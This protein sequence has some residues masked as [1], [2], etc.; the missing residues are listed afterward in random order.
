MP[1]TGQCTSKT[2]TSK[3]PENSDFNDND[4]IWASDDEKVSAYADRQ[5]AQVNQGYL[6]GLTAAQELGL[7]NGFDSGYPEGATLGIRVGKV[8]AKLHGTALFDQAKRELNITK[9]L[10]SK[11]YDSHLDVKAPDHQLVE[12]WEQKAELTHSR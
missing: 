10:D 3:K 7:Q 9:V 2:K 6:D 4:D 11:Y 1:C 12:T 5:R 8:L